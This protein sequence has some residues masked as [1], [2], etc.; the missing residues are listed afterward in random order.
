MK[1][2]KAMVVNILKTEERKMQKKRM[3][4][5]IFEEENQGGDGSGNSGNGNGGQNPGGTFT[6]EQLDEIASSRAERAG[7]AALKDYFKRNGLSE[8][9]ATQAFEKYK[10]EKAKSQPNTKEL[11]KEI[12]TYKAQIETMKNEGYLKDK[13]VKAD[14]MEYVVFKVSKMVDEKND[15]KKAADKFLKENPRFAENPYRVHMSS[16]TGSGNHD[17][18]G[19]GGNINSIINDSIRRA[20]RR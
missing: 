17:S 11:E 13:G 4:L 14:D 3:N 19:G 1:A 12:D 7:K 5:Y 16:S 9:E 20:A 18:A 15:F 8:E 10:E 2:K 6:Y